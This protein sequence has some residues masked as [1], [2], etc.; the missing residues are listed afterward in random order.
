MKKFEIVNLGDLP[1][2][3]RFYFLGD[4]RKKIYEVK[5]QNNADT[6]LIYVAK[7]VKRTIA[8]K[9]FPSQPRKTVFLL[10]MAQ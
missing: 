1:K 2:G 5:C 6:D 8:H 3:A 4:G 7:N 9:E 10:L